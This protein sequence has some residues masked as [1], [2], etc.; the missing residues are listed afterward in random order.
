MDERKARSNEDQ[1]W[2]LFEKLKAGHEAKKDT[3][4]MDVYLYAMQVYSKTLADL[5]QR[6]INAIRKQIADTNKLKIEL[7]KDIEA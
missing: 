7:L 4:P 6:D 3:V 5:E 1:F 2:S